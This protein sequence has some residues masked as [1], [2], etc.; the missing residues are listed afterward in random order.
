MN[1]SGT[2]CETYSMIKGHTVDDHE[3]L[4][5]VFVGSV[6]SVPCHHIEG[7]EV[8]CKNNHKK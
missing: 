1:H 4:Q 3:V 6:V 2:V 5:V 8:L 7:R